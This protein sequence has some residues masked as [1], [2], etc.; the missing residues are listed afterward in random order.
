[1]IENRVLRKTF[2]LKSDDVRG[3]WRRLHEKELYDLY[4][5]V[6]SRRTRRGRGYVASMGNVRGACMHLMGLP[7]ENKPL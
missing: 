1:V 5:V 7:E 4:P 3:D 6:T 2:G